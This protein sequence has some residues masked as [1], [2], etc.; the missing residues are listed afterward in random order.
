MMIP[1]VDT[2]FDKKSYRPIWKDPLNK[3]MMIPNVDT[4]FDKIFMIYLD[5]D[6]NCSKY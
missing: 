6:Q 2:N 3:D 1:N 5:F 4:N